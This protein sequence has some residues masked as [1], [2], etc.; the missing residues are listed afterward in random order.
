MQKKILTAVS[1]ALAL[2]YSYQVFLI[3]KNIISLGS[4]SIYLL[5]RFIPL[6]I[7]VAGLVIFIK[8][9]FTKG[10]ML[11]FYLCLQVLLGPVSIWSYIDYFSKI[12]QYQYFQ[13]NESQLY[14]V[15]LEFVIL[16]INFIASA[17]G[18]WIITRKRTAKIQYVG[19]DE[20]R[21]AEFSPTSAGKRFINYLVDIIIVLVLMAGYV[22]LFANGGD[23]MFDESSALSFYFYQI[24]F[25]LIYYTVL[26]SVFYTTAGKCLTNT[27]VVNEYAERPG[28]MQVVGRSFSRLIP[29]EAFSFL[30]SGRGW[31]D[32]LT[33]SYV[34]DSIDRDELN[35]YEITLDI[36]QQD[37]PAADE[38]TGSTSN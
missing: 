19:N 26:E 1:I 3:L 35:K 36:E 16:C 23:K 34:V 21:V 5:V 17:V 2:C 11:A 31:H 9:S 22:R 27:I 20:N 15:Y 12:N 28:F 24:P 14:W 33:N 13:N 18:L 4:D 29:L 6:F 38:T 10:N 7:A 32:S 8:S 25:L 37:K 30:G